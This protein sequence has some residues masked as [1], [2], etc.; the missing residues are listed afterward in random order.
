ML[1]TPVVRR[2]PKDNRTPKLQLPASPIQKDDDE[3]VSEEGQKIAKLLVNLH[4]KILLQ[5]I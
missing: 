5:P 1:S 2:A 3:N 4:Y